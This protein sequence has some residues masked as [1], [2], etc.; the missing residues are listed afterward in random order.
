MFKKSR[1][2][3]A[4]KT[5]YEVDNLCPLCCLINVCLYISVQIYIENCIH[6]IDLIPHDVLQGSKIGRVHKLMLVM[7]LVMVTC[8]YKNRSLSLSLSMNHAVCIRTRIQLDSR[9]NYEIEPLLKS[10]GLFK[11]V[12]AICSKCFSCNFVMMCWQWSL[13]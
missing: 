6:K 1:L 7:I 10:L 5:A 3:V 2:N 4:L 9:K 12:Y 13:W 11:S 8:S